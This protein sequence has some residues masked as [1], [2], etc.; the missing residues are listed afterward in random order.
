MLTCWRKDG[1]YRPTGEN[2]A[3]FRAQGLGFTEFKE[4]K[5][6]KESIEVNIAFLRGDFER[7]IAERRYRHGTHPSPSAVHQ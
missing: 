1:N 5:E 2:K 7:E 6:F 4:F 3:R